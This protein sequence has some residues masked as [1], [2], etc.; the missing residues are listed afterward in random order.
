MVAAETKRTPNSDERNGKGSLT[1]PVDIVIVAWNSRQFLEGCL[2]SLASLQPAANRILI[3]DN[4]STDGS[5]GWVQENHPQVEWIELGRNAG[6]CEAN[7]IGI[8]KSEAP[9]VLVLNPDTELEPNFLAELLPAFDTPEVGLASGKL[10]RF[11]GSTIDTAGQLLGRSRQPID[12]GYGEADRGQFDKEI[13]LFGACGAAALYRRE[14]LDSIADG[15]DFFDT[16]FFAFVEDLDIAWRAQ[17]LGW[18]CRYRPTAVGRHARG[19]SATGPRWKRRL[20][21]M[22]GRSPE[23]RFHIAKNRYLSIL[24]NDS[25]ASYLKD[26]PFIFARDLGTLLLL[27]VSSPAVLV[28]LWRERALFRRAKELRRLDEARPRIQVR[29]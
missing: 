26:F 6:F 29:L 3:V 11:D 21:S 13:D 18:R 15:D 19:G 7:N 2:A 22:L 23:V 24:R 28:R 20:A 14:M 27:L 4:G 10:L 5:S 16:A 25:V 9:F 8:R 1:Q 17:K 12:R